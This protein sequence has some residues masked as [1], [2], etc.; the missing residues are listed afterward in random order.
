MH[1]IV[2]IAAF[3]IVLL[4]WT[5]VP[6]ENSKTST[7]T[8]CGGPK[9]LSYEKLPNALKPIIADFNLGF[10][11]ETVETKG[12][13]ENVKMVAK[14]ECDFGLAPNKLVNK[15]KLPID[16]VVFHSYA[17]LVCNQQRTKNAKEIS[18]LLKQGRKIQ[19]AV[20]DIGSASKII[21]DSLADLD[22]KFGPKNFSTMPL[23]FTKAIPLVMNGQYDCAWT[24]SG[25]GS[26]ALKAADY[27]DSSKVLRLI[28]VNDSDFNDEDYEF[29][30]I[31][32]TTY[33]NLQAG[34][35]MDVKTIDI[36]VV[37]FHR[38]GLQTQNPV[39]YGAISGEAL[40]VG[41]DLFKE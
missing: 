20:G 37:L 6:A 21:W 27:P 26:P 39:A 22:D 36:P 1:R 25:V 29:F 32:K 24:V 12:G 35:F 38:K 23:G 8:F 4:S 13:E 18:D 34:W 9:G 40:R 31:P 2:S 15:R 41:P 19:I 10:T 14:G 16:G 3:I 28:D 17:H 33:P 30:V 11:L 5:S 7:V